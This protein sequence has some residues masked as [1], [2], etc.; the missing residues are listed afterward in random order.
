[1]LGSAR[2]FRSLRSS[3]SLPMP[4]PF[5]RLLLLV[6]LAL[7][8]CREQPDPAKAFLRQHRSDDFSAFAG[9]YF[10]VRGFDHDTGEAIVFLFYLPTAGCAV[11]RYDYKRQRSRFLEF[12][13]QGNP[14]LRLAS[15]DTALMNRFMR[16]NVT[17]LE[18]DPGGTVTVTVHAYNPHITLLQTRDIKTDARPGET[19]AAKGGNWYES[20]EE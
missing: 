15:T 13:S 9:T 2:C 19:Y 12:L 16:L 18:V 10:F 1:M 17:G 14:D 4:N 11:Y 6:L 3:F 5:A 20:R 7:G 8:A